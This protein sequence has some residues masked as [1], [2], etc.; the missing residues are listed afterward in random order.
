MLAQGPSMGQRPLGHGLGRSVVRR[1]RAE[2][3]ARQ[4]AQLGPL[5]RADAPAERTPLVAS[6]NGLFTRLI[7]PLLAQVLLR[8]LLDNA[9]RYSP[10]GSAVTVTLAATTP[11]AWRLIVEDAGPGLDASDLAR[12]CQRSWGLRVQV[13][14]D[15]AMGTGAR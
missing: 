3:A 5:T 12:L 13:N 1:L 11:G 8:N 7:D 4:Q 14:H 9:L 2:L 15:P 6:L 10:P